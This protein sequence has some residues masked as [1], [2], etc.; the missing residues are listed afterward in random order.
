[1]GQQ[2]QK[3]YGQE[4]TSAKATADKG[5]NTKKPHSKEQ[6]YSKAEAAKTPTKTSGQD[7]IKEVEQP[8]KPKIGKKKERSKKYQQSLKLVDRKKVYNLI[9]AIEL[10]K[11]TS[12]AKFDSTLELHI[13]TLTKKGQEPIRA[14]VAMPAGAVK[15]PKVAVVTDELIQEIEKGKLNFD[16]LLATPAMMPKLAKYA[17]VLGP[18]GLMPSPKAGTIVDDPDK[19]KTEIA[20]GRVE[21]RQDSLGNIHTAV[22]K[23][24]WPSDKIKQNVGAILGSIQSNRVDRLTLS[25]TMGPGIKAVKN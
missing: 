8:K 25:A 15:T 10:A 23:V 12:Y 7:E 17:K 4:P 5:K 19:A 14:L 9:D 2:K 13:K 22:G 3:I 21:I 1:M 24:S 11:K 6:D 18:K 16:T 20:K